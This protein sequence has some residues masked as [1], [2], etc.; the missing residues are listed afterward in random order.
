MKLRA[1][2][3]LTSLNALSAAPVQARDWGN[4]GGWYV[5][6]GTQSCGMYAPNLGA[7]G[8]TEIIIL[9]RLDGAIYVQAQD[10]AWSVSRGSEGRIQY[11]I[12]GRN[13]AGGINATGHPTKPGNGVLAAFNGDFE[14]VLRGGTNLSFLIDGRP[15]GQ[16]ALSG[17]SAA[18]A[19]VQSCLDDLRRNPQ[20]ATVAQATPS[21]AGFASLSVKDPVPK[22]GTDDW[23]SLDDYPRDALRSNRE[24]TTGFNLV[25]GKDGRA[26][27]CTISKSSGH[28]DLDTATCKAMMRRARFEPAQDAGRNPVEGKFSSRVS[29]KVPK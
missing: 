2:I 28:P 15:L 27:Q 13:Y 9:K 29:W 18:M 1:L 24:G 17:T 8:A 16:V 14:P 20:S 21:N 22:G 10:P 19:T 25:V 7:S 6:S 12:D 4:V 3:A 26:Q 11:Q 23:I 5:T